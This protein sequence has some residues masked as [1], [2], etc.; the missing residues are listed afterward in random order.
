LEEIWKRLG[1]TDAP[2]DC[3]AIITDHSFYVIE[4]SPRLGGNS[5]STLLKFAMD[6]DIVEYAVRLAC[7]E[8]MTDC[9]FS[10]V[11]KTMAIILLG[12]Q[13]K[14]QLTYDV[15]NLEALKSEPWIQFLRIDIALGDTVQP[16]INGRHRIGEA[17]ITGA[18]RDDLDAHAVELRNRLKLRGE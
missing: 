10:D 2:F 12:V 5:I 11:V 4:L 6:F 7:G 18:D 8:A 1:I 13:E 14:G 3:D 9:W 17:L 16:F 15:M